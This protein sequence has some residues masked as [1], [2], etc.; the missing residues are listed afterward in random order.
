MTPPVLSLRQIE[1]PRFNV[2]NDAPNIYSDFGFWYIE[3]M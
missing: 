1:C 3:L 2:L